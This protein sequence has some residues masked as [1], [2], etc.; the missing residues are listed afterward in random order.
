MEESDYLED[1]DLSWNNLKPQDFDIFFAPLSRSRSL[2]T[3]NLSGNMILDEASQKNYEIDPDLMKEEVLSYIERKRDE[4]K[5]ES[6]KP[7]KSMTPNFSIEVVLC[8]RKL[9]KYSPSI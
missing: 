7:K 5:K 4:M 3:L 9:L 1:L 6:N 2:R 8:L